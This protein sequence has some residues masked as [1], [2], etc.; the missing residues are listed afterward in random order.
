V[1][2]TISI[3]VILFKIINCEAK[4]AKEKKSVKS[5][6]PDKNLKNILDFFK[7]ISDIPRLSGNEEE[8]RQFLIN[9]ARKNKYLYITDKAGNLIIKVKGSKGLE[10]RKPVVLQ[11][12]LD[13]VGEKTPD[14]NHDFSKDPIKFVF[15]G[16]WLK[17]DKTTL[18]AD[19]GIAIAIAMAICE[20][21]TVK[22]PP[23][24]LLF[25]VEE[26]T[27]L[28]GAKGLEA[29]ILTGKTL[30]NI[31]SED[32]GI[33][34]V[35]C[36]GGKDTHIELSL[37]YEEVPKEYMAVLIKATGMN[38]GHSGVNIHEERANAV[39]V[40]VRTLMKIRSFCDL[41]IVN[42]S[43]GTA[44]NAIPRD[45][46]ATIFIPSDVLDKIK[47]II[48]E[49]E[50]I[51]KS[52][53]AR[54]DPQ[55]KLLLEPIPLPIDRRGM[56][57]FTSMKVLDLIFAIPHGIAARST[58]MPSLVETSANQAKIWVETGKL[59]MLTSQRSSVMSRL[60]AHTNRIESIARL[61]GARVVSGNGYP[62]WQPDFNSKLVKICVETYTKVFDKKPKVEA[63]HAGLECG[64]I[65][66]AVPGMSMIS[67]G[68]TIQNPHSPDERISLPS[69]EKIWKFMIALLPEL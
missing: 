7:N 48:S 4:M 58:E 28:T 23:L 30:I 29:D 57:S 25:T 56:M 8:I 45:A 5:F 51:F 32:E 67:I 65:G 69:I 62:A 3:R 1:L 41:R 47:N 15:D 9:W 17:A 6:K 43:G 20:D 46:E 44:H 18:G 35:G 36:A 63:I 64:I 68:P 60:E 11:G 12:H 33:F 14:S 27:G 55:L 24:E 13:M 54:T 59:H 53:F 16:E 34:T 49:C 19:N 21:P 22:H 31:D 42:L 2:K 61:A 66:D 40:L 37:D 50:I 38:G 26:E 52:E 10:K 39:R